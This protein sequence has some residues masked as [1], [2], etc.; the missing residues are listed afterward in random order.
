MELAEFRK[1]VSELERENE[2]L[3][4]RTTEL[5]KA[6][7]ERTD[8]EKRTTIA[9]CLQHFNIHFHCRPGA[10]SEERRNVLRRVRCVV[11]H[12]RQDAFYSQIKKADVLHAIERSLPR[13]ET[14]KSKRTVD[15]KR[16]FNLLCEPR[17]ED[18]L[19]F[20]T[21]PA[22]NIKYLGPA[23]L[24]KKRRSYLKARIFDD[25]QE[26]LPRLDPYWRAL[27]GTLCFAGLRLAEAAAL[28]WS[29]V[30]QKKHLILVEPTEIYPELKSEVSERPIVPFKELWP[31]LEAYAHEKPHETWVFPRPLAPNQTWF[32]EVCGTP[33][34]NHLS[35]ELSKALG[36]A[37]VEDT[38]EPSRK[39]RRYWETRLRSIGRTDLIQIMGGHS[40]KVGR[41]HYTNALIVVQ[42]I[43]D[44]AFLGDVEPMQKGNG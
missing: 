25:P 28:Q 41:D 7:G 42:G 39:A 27:F 40:E 2:S 21:N 22:R 35:R 1:R 20:T 4:L 10:K 18:G 43:T 37:G 44:D 23:A 36:K 6:L 32:L 3:R 13:S 26:I 31:I 17:P 29:R 30:D 34:V 15:I 14:E 12:V 11:E 38:R 33:K 9:E 16:F 5:V 8:A 24:R 19:G